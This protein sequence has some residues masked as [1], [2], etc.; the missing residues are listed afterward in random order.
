MAAEE[1][2]P[3]AR[4]PWDPAYDV[5]HP[6]IDTQHRALIDQCNRLADLCLADEAAF[7]AAFA[8]LKADAQAHFEA[9]S[10][11]LASHA[12]ADLEDHRIEC[13]EFG[14][15]AN[16]IATTA[17]FDRLELQRFVALWWVGHVAGSAASLQD[18][19]VR[20]HRPA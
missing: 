2:L 17:H 13:D 15:L 9:E 11:L 19:A 4:V 10:A 6:L 3:P 16:E 7:D 5:G 1:T 8:T 20:A 12:W 14:Y 18:L